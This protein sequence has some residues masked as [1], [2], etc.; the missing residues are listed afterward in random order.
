MLGTRSLFSEIICRPRDGRGFLAHAHTHTRQQ[1][2]RQPE[3]CGGPGRPRRGTD[4]ED[5][6]EIREF[7]EVCT[8]RNWMVL[9]TVAVAEEWR[10]ATFPSP[11]QLTSTQLSAVSN[12]R[13]YPKRHVREHGWIVIH[14][15]HHR[16]VWPGFVVG[17][18][19][20]R[21][22]SSLVLGLASVERLCTYAILRTYPTYE[23]MSGRWSSGVWRWR[24]LLTCYW[25]PRVHIRLVR[26]DLASTACQG[27][28][29]YSAVRRWAV[30]SDLVLWSLIS[31]HPF[32]FKSRPKE[33]RI[34]ANSE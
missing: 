31:S 21:S 1:Q 8:A 22:L 10:D 4:G 16:L 33:R 9:A 24:V 17:V 32:P 7:A 25:P 3:D 15:H 34:D 5:A 2:Q 27:L 29:R 28:G 30:S 20:D 18:V 26:G 6:R 11:L 14:C 12:P 23:P 19:S 13:E